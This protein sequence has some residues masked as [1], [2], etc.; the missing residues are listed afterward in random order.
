VVGKVYNIPAQ[1]PVEEHTHRIPAG[2]LTFGV[3]YRDLD[4]ESLKATYAGNAK[5]LAELEDKSPEGGFTD[6]GVSIHVFETEGGHEY[7]R[8]DVFDGEPHYHYIHRTA[9]GEPVVNNVIDFD[10]TAHG[11]MLPW[12]VERLRNR[13]PEMLGQAGGGHLAGRLDAEEI[14]R[15]VD[16][17]ATMAEDAQRAH[18]AAAG[19]S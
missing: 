5:H 18:R 10:V 16:D 9:P 19:R 12:V 8:F 11:E 17:V 7:L 3:E 1:P 14:S 2:V 6:E 13:L 15:A 4:P